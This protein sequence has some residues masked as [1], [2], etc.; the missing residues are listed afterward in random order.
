MDDW[1]AAAIYIKYTRFL[2]GRSTEI[3]NEDPNLILKHDACTVDAVASLMRFSVARCSFFSIPKA[4][5][6]SGI[7]LF[8]E[9]KVS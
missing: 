9:T 5:L 6:L 1:D 7:V 8:Q 2:Q 4:H 3:L